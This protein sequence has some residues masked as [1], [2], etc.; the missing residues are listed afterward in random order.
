[1][2][3]VKEKKDGLLTFFSGLLLSVFHLGTGISRDTSLYPYCSFDLLAYFTKFVDHGNR[4]TDT[5]V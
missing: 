5:E 2:K 4:C 3:S 1:M